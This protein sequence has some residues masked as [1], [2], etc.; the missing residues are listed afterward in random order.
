M[1]Q[2]KPFLRKSQFRHEKLREE[3]RLDKTSSLFSSSENQNKG[4]QKRTD[5]C[6]FYKKD[7]KGNCVPPCKTRKN[8]DPCPPLSPSNY[9]VISNRSTSTSNAITSSKK[10]F[11]KNTSQCKYNEWKDIPN[12]CSGTCD[13]K[14]MK[15]QKKTPKTP[16]NG[17]PTCYRSVPCVVGQPCK[18]RSI[19]NKLTSN[20]QTCNGSICREG[21][22]GDQCI[23]GC[24]DADQQLEGPNK[25]TCER[26]KWLSNTNS[27]KSQ[28][29]PKPECSARFQTC[30]DL[31]GGP[32][33]HISAS[34]YDPNDREYKTSV[35]VQARGG[36]KCHIYCRNGY[37]S[38]GTDKGKEG[39][40]ML[41]TCVMDGNTGERYWSPKV[42]DKCQ[43]EKCGQKNEVDMCCPGASGSDVAVENDPPARVDRRSLSVSSSL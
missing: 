9:S 36:D 41:L 31:K 39:N 30:P 16:G 27:M 7:S 18:C 25:F 28:D 5:A 17:C 8:H 23:V 22:P 38:V 20:V 29:Q 33:Y 34:Y 15:R 6:S 35:C 12:T 14:A 43:C 10:E 26:G 24:D 11:C 1:K 3:I 37:A 2:V 4:C 21:N 40:N 19:K 32:Q 13:G 42:K